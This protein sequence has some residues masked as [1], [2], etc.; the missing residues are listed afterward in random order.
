MS[1]I[2]QAWNFA[3]ADNRLAE[4]MKLFGCADEIAPVDYVAFSRRMGELLTRSLTPARLS[5]AEPAHVEAPRSG[6]VPRSQWDADGFRHRLQCAP[7]SDRVIMAAMAAASTSLILVTA[8][9]KLLAQ[10][11]VQIMNSTVIGLQLAT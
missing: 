11:E 3:P 10:S 2:A 8:T 5:T 9:V 6:E 7:R 4:L 1:Q